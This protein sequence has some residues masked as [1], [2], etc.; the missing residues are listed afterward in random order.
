MI[1]DRLERAIAENDLPRRADPK[2][3]AGFIVAVMRGMAVEAAS[4]TPRGPCGKSLVRENGR[5]NGAL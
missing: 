4:G 3:L 1:Q 5:E 2:A